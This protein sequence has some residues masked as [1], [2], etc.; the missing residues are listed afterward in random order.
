MKPENVRV[1]LLNPAPSLIKYGMK[2]GFEQIG[3][4][5]HLLEGTEAIYNLRGKHE[6]ALKIV[7]NAIIEHKINF[8][9][10]EGYSSM[11]INEIRELCNKY[12]IVLH[13]WAIEDPVVPHIGENI[14]NNKLADFI[15]TTTVE[16]IPKYKKMG[17]DS[18]LLLFACNPDFHKPVVGEDRFKHDISVIG[19]N[20]SSRYDKTKEFVL[21]LID[22][23]FDIMIYGLWWMNPT[24]PVNLCKYKDKGI[25]WQ[26]EGYDQ[27]P[28]EWL[29]IVIN[30]SKIMI[31]LNCSS[32]SK[33][34]TS[35]RPYETLCSSAESV[36]LAY[37]TDAQEE[38][39]GDYIIQAKNGREMIDK[40]NEILEWSPA[41]RRSIAQEARN[42]VSENHNYKL[43]AKQVIDKL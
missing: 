20:Y 15:W 4:Y 40:A 21:P 27:L 31:G 24:I 17:I 41:K 34:Q 18:D 6:E 29:P 14:A 19:T 33:T 1:L 26:E 5:V 36:Y 42:Y 39:F 25:Y 23:D 32:L 22:R 30:S 9:F 2:W 8:I 16:F 11:P 3:C 12:S 43:R 35:C 37:Y 13:W 38:I 10:T 28:Y 7:E